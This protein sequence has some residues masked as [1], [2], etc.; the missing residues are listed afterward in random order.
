MSSPLI[1]KT[2]LKN[3]ELFL[4]ILSKYTNSNFEDL[5]T[6]YLYFNSN[7]EID[8]KFEKKDVEKVIN[9]TCDFF[10]LINNN[11]SFSIKNL[12]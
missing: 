11:Y 8:L 12:I 9:K 7:K 4:S 2:F 3:N 1:E 5:K 10:F 6:K